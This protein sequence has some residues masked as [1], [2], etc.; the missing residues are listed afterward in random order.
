[1]LFTGLVFSFVDVDIN[2]YKDTSIIIKQNGGDL[3][4]PLASCFGLQSLKANYI[5]SGS[6]NITKS[7]IM[8]K[9]N[10]K[11]IDSTVNIVN[12]QFVYDCIESNR[13]FTSNEIVSM[14]YI[15]YPKD[16]S[17]ID[18]D[19]NTI[20]KKRLINED[21]KSNKVKYHLDISMIMMINTTIFINAR[22]HHY[23]LSRRHKVL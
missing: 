11:D 12:I 19:D 3:Y 7:D 21:N 17:I 13:I 16:N 22:N 9:L 14:G 4:R 8:S 15:V 1:M 20:G 6:N 23:L 18:I 10:C 2:L 5:I